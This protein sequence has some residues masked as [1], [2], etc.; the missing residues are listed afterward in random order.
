MLQ[1]NQELISNEIEQSEQVRCRATEAVATDGQCVTIGELFG[2]T[3]E[4]SRT[5]TIF[6]FPDVS[7]PLVPPAN[8]HYC[9]RKSSLYEL[10]SFLVS[11]NGDA[12][13]ITGPTGSGKTSLVLETAARLNYPVQSVTINGRMEFAELRGLFTVCSPSPGEAPQTVFKYGPLVNAMRYGHILLLNELD[14]ADP[15]ELA[16]LNDVLEGRPLIIAENGGEVIYPHP[17]FRV[18]ATGNSSGCGDESGLYQGVITQNLACMDRFRFMKVDYAQAK[19][20]KGITKRL[21]PDF[22]TETLDKMIQFANEIRK[23][24]VGGREGLNRTS[25]T[26]STRTLIRWVH[27]STQLKNLPGVKNSL[28][29][30]LDLALLNRANPQDQETIRQIAFQVFGKQWETKPLQ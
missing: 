19:V 5:R 23:A 13:F 6:R 3:D 4:D 16:G 24:F 9:F 17:S 1:S 27:L 21:F 26:M 22:P 12:L 2:L 25:I 14:L 20:E 15:A 7:D 18:I 10:L 29:Y 8:P 28:R 30:A 11:P